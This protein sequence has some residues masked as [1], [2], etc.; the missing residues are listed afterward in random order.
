MGPFTIIT[1]KY[2]PSNQVWFVPSSM[3][4][5][6]NLFEDEKE[7]DITEY[8]SLYDTE[9]P[10]FGAPYRVKKK[11]CEC[12]AIHT[13]IPHNHSDY[14]PLYDKDQMKRKAKED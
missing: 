9:Y 7:E 4:N 11:K 5:G 8:D 1:S 14:C 2:A 6:V 13:M 10:H 3:S 12:G